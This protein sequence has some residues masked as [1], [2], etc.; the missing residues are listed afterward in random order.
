MIPDM[1]KEFVWGFGV[2]ESTV[3]PLFLGRCKVRVVSIHSPDRRELPTDSLPW[4]TPLQSITSA[5]Q[6]GVGTSPT[7]LVP[8]SWV[9][10]FFRDGELAQ[11]PIILGSLGGIPKNPREEN[12]NIGF[13]D[14]RGLNTELYEFNDNWQQPNRIREV[15]ADRAVILPNTVPNKPSQL[16]V[17]GKGVSNKKNKIVAFSETWEP[18]PKI[19][20][21][22]EPTTP[23]VARGI[24]DATSKVVTPDSVIDGLTNTTVNNMKGINYWKETLRSAMS[25]KIPAYYNEAQSDP[26]DFMETAPAYGAKYPYNHAHETESGHT[27]ELDDTPGAERMHWWHRTGTYEEWRPDGGVQ[28]RVN[29]DYKEF[30][31]SDKFTG[32]RG[33]SYTTAQGRIQFTAGNSSQSDIVLISPGGS[34]KI[35]SKAN[36]VKIRGKALILE[37]EEQITITSRSKNVPVLMEVGAITKT[38]TGNYNASVAGN[39]STKSPSGEIALS[40]QT[41][42]L[43]TGI[44]GQLTIGVG[45]KFI[46]S[47]KNSIETYDNPLIGSG[48]APASNFYAKRIEMLNGRMQV[49]AI[50]TSPYPGGFDVIV[51]AAP[52]PTNPFIPEQPIGLAEFKVSPPTNPLG[53]TMTS[54]SPSPAGGVLTNAI[55]INQN[56][57]GIV[58]TT[59]PLIET[60]G[61]L[62][63]LTSDITVVGARVGSEP[64]ILGAKFAEQYAQHVHVSPCGT[65]G[66]PTT[67][68]MI[69][70]ALS[71]KGF[72]SG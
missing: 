12:P 30:V 57:T 27:I 60:S 8:G 5:A 64:M 62:T 61:A 50:A 20:E 68:T 35:Q 43:S 59:A 58:T 53:I 49:S 56:A 54:T 42:N 18:Y 46:V 26:I 36:E 63:A 72:L 34:V 41:L 25:F 17:A 9:M 10:V 3:D 67:A 47:A 69:Q 29:G 28:K 21:L 14:P 4:A 22:K 24:N 7:G 55:F 38:I 71:R 19:S 16:Y 66:P 1:Q 6:T 13:Q 70:S 37:A 15:D 39:W 2:V 32:I 51:K 31:L 45:G 23:R 44:M 11:E 40:G 48:D 52:V 33:N 65:T